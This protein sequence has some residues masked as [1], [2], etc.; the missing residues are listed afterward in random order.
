MDSGLNGSRHL[1]SDL[2]LERMRERDWVCYS[3]NLALQF[4]SLEKLELSSAGRVGMD[5]KSCRTAG[6]KDGG[7]PCP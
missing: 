1:A 5:V 7:E 4:T 2:V 6:A 3:G